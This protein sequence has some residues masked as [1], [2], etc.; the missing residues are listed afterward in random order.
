MWRVEDRS[1]FLVVMV[2]SLGVGCVR[3][4]EFGAEA[5]KKR[6]SHWARLPQCVCPPASLNTNNN[7]D[8]TK[9][10]DYRFLD[11]PIH[12]SQDRR[13]A[14]NLHPIVHSE[15]LLSCT[16]ALEVRRKRLQPL[17]VKSA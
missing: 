14:L 17:A 2:S 3:L 8:N 16:A 15:H 5:K 10:Q 9:G 1:R 7:H 6:L 12:F 11:L 4:S 13:F